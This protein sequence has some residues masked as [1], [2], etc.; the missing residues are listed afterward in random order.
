[1]LKMGDVIQKKNI[2]LLSSFA[3]AP[4]LGSTVLLFVLFLVLYTAKNFTFNK[5][6][7]RAYLPI[8]IIGLALIAYFCCFAILELIHS[9][10]LQTTTI[11]LGKIFPIF[12]IG[13][14]GLFLDIKKC[15]VKYLDIG[16]AAIIGVYLTIFCALFFKFLF[17]EYGFVINDLD[18]HGR[19]TMFSGNALPFGTM[20]ITLSFLTLLGFT[21][22]SPPKKLIAVSAFIIGILTVWLWNQ[23][24]GP[25]LSTLP[26]LFVTLCVIIIYFNFYRKILFYLI[27]TLLT[28]ILSMIFYYLKDYIIHFLH[29]SPLAEMI[30]P[31]TTYEK[32]W[33][34]YRT[35]F[36]GKPYDISVYTRMVMY[37]ASI[38]T[39]FASPLIG[40]GLDGMGVAILPF[41]PPEWAELT[42]RHFH[43]IFINHF[44]AGGIFGLIALTILLV[45]PLITL[46][47]NKNEKHKDAII[48][49]FIIMTSIIFNGLTNL[50]FFHD[51][52]GAFFAILILLN[53]IASY[54]KKDT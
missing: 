27:L 6:W 37:S 47:Y 30:G 5:P 40:H 50:I 54:N 22:K 46:Y 11:A 29:V 21:G 39:F 28:I 20:F 2:V 44:L 32:W 16:N 17:S 25:T 41:L 36:D 34:A 33:Y 45:S 31:A 49:S 43:N 42:Y 14:L 8:R 52:M 38:Q 18:V 19:L 3:L 48:C 24:R 35:F 12:V 10:N 15:T 9:E 7:F 26:L 53:S 4:L 13:L 51:L 23:S 1:M